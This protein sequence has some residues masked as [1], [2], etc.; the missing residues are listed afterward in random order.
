MESADDR[1]WS[2]V[3][4]TGEWSGFTIRYKPSPL[5]DLS[6]NAKRT[7][8]SVSHDTIPIAS[9]QRTQGGLDRDVIAKKK[10]ALFVTKQFDAVT[11]VTTKEQP[12]IYKFEEGHHRTA[13]CCKHFTTIPA[14]IVVIDKGVFDSYPNPSPPY[15]STAP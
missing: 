3:E 2:V 5:E 8:V 9:I 11:V 12:G 4:G 1:R 15:F 14:N 6:L 13:V 7:L 10:E